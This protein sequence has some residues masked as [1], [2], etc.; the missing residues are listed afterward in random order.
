MS[1]LK[2]PILTEKAT[3]LSNLGKYVFEVSKTANKIEIANAIE[4]VYGVKVAS[5]DT[6]RSIGRKKSR[7]SR[8]KAISGIT[9]TYKKAI[10]TLKAGEIIDIYSDIA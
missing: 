6:M 7:M 3:A 4:K 1:V 10:V 5:V 8:G 2:R 9:S